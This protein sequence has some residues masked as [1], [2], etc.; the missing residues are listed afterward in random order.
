MS[1]DGATIDG[2]KIHG[3]YDTTA[4]DGSDVDNGMFINADNVTIKNS[5]LDGTGLGDVRPFST[6][7]SVSGLD[8]NH[9]KVAHWDEGAY[10][11]LGGS[12]TSATHTVPPDGKRID[13]RSNAV[14]L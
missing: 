2:V 1:H 11:T 10:I 7:G 14:I 12:G 8:F 13:T 6:T 5:L 3:V 4:I 9:N